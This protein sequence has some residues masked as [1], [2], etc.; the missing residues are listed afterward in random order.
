[1]SKM[2]PVTGRVPREDSKMWV[3][4]GR[5]GERAELWYSHSRAS[6]WKPQDRD[7]GASDVLHR[8]KGARGPAWE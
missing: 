6:A 7:R 4:E 2:T 1:M 5:P 3:Q 8:G